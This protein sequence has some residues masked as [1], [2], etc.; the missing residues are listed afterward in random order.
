MASGFVVNLY[1]SPTPGGTDEKLA[2]TGAAKQFA[3]NWR[4]DASGNHKYIVVDVQ[5][6]DVMI[7]FD[8]STP[9]ST[10]GHRFYAGD[11]ATWS[12]NTAMAAKI[13]VVSADAVVHATGFTS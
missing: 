9:T 6:A 8:G 4:T 5:T 11:K 2:I 3:T 10:N 13:I 12:V 7:T 1:P